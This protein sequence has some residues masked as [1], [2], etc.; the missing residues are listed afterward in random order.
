MEPDDGLL[1]PMVNGGENRQRSKRLSTAVERGQMLRLRPGIGIR[2]ETWLRAPRWKQ[3]LL[4]AAA[5][6]A[7]D[8]SRIFARETSLALRGI[9]LLHTPEAVQIRAHGYGRN[10]RSP[11][12][13]LTGNADQ[14]TVSAMIRRVLSPQDP[15]RELWRL[16]PLPL[17]RIEAPLPRG[18]SRQQLRQ[19]IRS[20]QQRIAWEHVAAGPLG[21]AADPPPGYRVD[22]LEIALLTAVPAMSWPEAVTVL[23]AVKRQSMDV[24]QLVPHWDLLRTGAAERAFLGAW[25]FADA[26]SESALESWSR[27]VIHQ[28]GFAAPSLQ[29]E[30]VLPDGSLARVD[31]LWEDEGIIGEAD[32][33][34][35]YRAGGYTEDPDAERIREKRRQNAL[36]HLGYKVRRWEMRHLRDPGKLAEILHA[37]GVPRVPH[38]Q[39]APAN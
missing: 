8:E 11:V 24:D 32:G 25:E 7:Q 35:K 26:R 14:Q 1:L 18:I 16:R 28:L 2:P 3:F 36:E 6:A 38:R 30:I 15:Q 21:R 39:L 9:P 19:R 5:A 17:K 33:L 22:P 4:V 20:G 31:F 29:R 27:A 12:R 10:G 37:A 13:A 23:D 34:A